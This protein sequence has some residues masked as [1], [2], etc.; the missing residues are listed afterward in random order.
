MKRTRQTA[1]ALV[2]LLALSLTA[3]APGQDDYLNACIEAVAALAA[4]EEVHMISTTLVGE[5]EDTM[6]PED[7]W[8]Y[9]VSGEDRLVIAPAGDDDTL[10]S[11]YKDGRSFTTAP[12]D[13]VRAWEELQADANT[14]SWI[15]PE[16]DIGEVQVSSRKDGEGRTVVTLT[17]DRSVTEEG[18]T[19][20][21]TASGYREEY[22]L[23]GDGTLACYSLYYT[24]QTPNG[25]G[26]T[27]TICW[28]MRMEYPT[29]EP[30]E[31]TAYLDTLYAET[32]E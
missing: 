21:M 9:W 14:D 19:G 16:V 5:T 3:C 15:P 31:V 6:A 1:F 8:E 18:P 32:T 12:E 24:T 2:L 26:E 30:G 28:C 13:G 25:A 11:L 27:Q 17:G 23:N 7:T 20:Q 29:F 10:W 4:R 22:V